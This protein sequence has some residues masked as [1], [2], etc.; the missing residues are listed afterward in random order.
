MPATESFAAADNRS[1]LGHNKCSLQE[2]LERAVERAGHLL[3]AQGP[4]NVFIHHNTLHAF[5]HL[6][7]DAAVQQ[8]G[9]LFGCRPYLDEIN[10]HAKMSRGRIR[11]ENL[12]AALREDLGGRSAET[13]GTLATRLDLRLAMLR[14]PLQQGSPA[15]L[16]WFVAETDALARFRIEAPGEARARILDET[17]RWIMREV[18]P[19]HVALGQIAYDRGLHEALAGLF[20]K[21]G[22]SSIEVWSDATWEAFSLSAIW[23]FCREG[24]HGIKSAAS[25][26]GVPQRHRDFLLQAT[27]EDSDRLVNE[28]LGRFCAAFLDQGFAP[29]PL[30]H[31]DG[32][33]FQAFCGLYELPANAADRWLKPLPAELSRLRVGQTTPHESISES[34]ELLG[35]AEAEWDDYIAAAL[36][37][38]RG[39]AGMLYQ[40]EIRGDRVARPAP[41]SSLLEFL[42]VRLILDRLAVA[43]VAQSALGFSGRLQ[44]LRHSIRRPRVDTDQVEQRAFVVFQLAQLLGWSPAGLRRLSKACWGELVAEIEAFSSVDRRRVYHRAFEHRFREQTL[45]ALAAWVAPVATPAEAP[46][47]QVVT[48]LDEREESLRRH[49]EEVAPDVA[50]FGAAGFFSIPIYYRGAADAHFTPLCPVMIRPQHWVVED[51]TY[52]FEES[53]RRRALVRRII[54]ALS[55]RLHLGTRTFAAGALLSAGLGPLA[56]VPLVARILFPRLTARIRHIAGHLMRPPTITEL[57]LERSDPTPGP[58]AGHIGFSVDEMTAIVER[59]LRDI[60]LTSGF[61]RLVFVLGHGSTSLNNPHES[62]HDCGACGGG[63]GGPNARAFA[64]MANDPRV[65]AGLAQRGLHIP[66]ETVFVGGMHNTCSDDLTLYDLDRLPWSHHNQFEQARDELERACDRNAHERSR[67]FHS[68]RLDFSFEEAR[69]H[70]EE[71]SEDL[72]QTRPEYGHAT[73]AVCVVGRRERTRGLFMDRRAFLTSYD[74][75]RDDAERS[76][77]T[78]IL[79]AVIPVCGGISLE[80]YFSYVDSTGW[81]CGTKLPHNVTS[82]LGIMDGAASDLRPG[83]PWQMVEIHEPVRILFVIEAEPEALVRIMDRNEG[84]GRLVRNDWVQLAALDPHSAKIHLFRDGQFEIYHPKSFDLPVVR[85]S[86]DWYRGWRDHLGYARVLPDVTSPRSA[87]RRRS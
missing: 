9:R 63:R 24:V 11:E 28:V 4:I 61:S 37:A 54:G 42:A 62:A 53:H 1:L 33:F 71:R 48:C 69:R 60:G 10:Y 41:A 17:R 19:G 51:V 87:Q 70:V 84:I 3:P 86:V 35:V 36:L 7:F 40:L 47:F 21:F 79:Q 78:R 22:E 32:G 43:W 29:W 59:L 58:E 74:P 49:L 46:R 13:V 12:R 80:Y 73:N 77:L 85:A 14:H 81:G 34:L 31:R 38:L 75:N 64:R 45:D 5:E 23:R 20:R 66:S 65:R 52:S 57:R 39:W 83:L 76:I 25:A 15:E 67:R 16:R 2:R 6:P 55:H 44:D 56:S 27:G 26:E 50:T 82:L 18:R 72:G 30:P 8:G 68:A